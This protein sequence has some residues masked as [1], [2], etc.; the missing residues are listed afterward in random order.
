MPLAR[1][2]PLL[3]GALVGG[4]AYAAG[5]RRAQAEQ[6]ETSRQAAAA[7]TP[8]P[9]PSPGASGQAAGGELLDELTRL[10][11]LRSQGVL[12]EEEFTAAKARLLGT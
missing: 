11:E 2:R 6:Q 1:R 9:Q 12:T 7:E 3:R 10:G 5:R 4:T 8:A